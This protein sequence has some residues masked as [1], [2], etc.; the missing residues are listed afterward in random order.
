MTLPFNCPHCKANYEVADEL[1]GKNIMCRVCQKRG[2]VGSAAGKTAGAGGAAGISLAAKDPSRRNFL[3][4]GGVTVGSVLSI[5]TG[6]ILAR[7][8][9]WNPQTEPPPE[10][11][12]RRGPGPGGPPPDGGK[13]EDKG[14]SA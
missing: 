13:K 8:R 11:G 12:R 5:A 4:I 10:G 6:A 7:W 3:F 14:P 9:Y 2:Q 1:G